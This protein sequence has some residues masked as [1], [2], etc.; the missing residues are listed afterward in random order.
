MPKQLEQSILDRGVIQSDRNV[1]QKSGI[2]SKIA[3]RWLHHLGYNWK[4]VQKGVFYD[5]HKHPDVIEYH[6]KFLSD[7]DALKPYLVEFEK[8]SLM[9][10]KSYPQ[11]YMVRGPDQRPII[12]ITHD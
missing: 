4:D 2:R 9:K 5:R 10:P 3:R 6:N 1:N 12:L 11:D 8:D 7:M